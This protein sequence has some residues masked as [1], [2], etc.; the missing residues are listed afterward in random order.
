ME[1]L[2][3]KTIDL[4]LDWATHEAAK[5][6]CEKWHYSKSVPVPP[7]VKVGV[8]ESEIYIGCVLFSR[9][10][11]QNLVKPYGLKQTEGCELTR[12]ALKS[13]AAP[14]SRIM[15]L[16]IKFLKKSN[17][18]LRLIV[19]FADP[20]QGHYG[21]IYQATNW[22][23]T[24]KTPPSVEYLDYRGNRWHGRQVSKAGV[25]VQFGSARKTPKIAD[26][27]KIYCDGKHRYLYPLDKSIKKRVQ[28]L[29]KP[30]PK[31]AGSKDSV[32][33]CDQQGEGG[34]N[35]TPALQNQ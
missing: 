20:N 23:Y 5:Y 17:P 12:I 14:V 16:A 2:L 29:S 13:H 3:S 9:G 15:S 11:T 18:K 32:A 33:S 34:A 1:N 21:G 7:L 28:A 35:P 6:A 26:C 31:R 25:K 30:Y 24:G 27:E 8:W 10:A 22:I 19:S 4:K